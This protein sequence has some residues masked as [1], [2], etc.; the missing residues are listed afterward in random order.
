MVSLHRIIEDWMETNQ[1]ANRFHG[2]MYD[3]GMIWKPYHRH[4][5][6]VTEN[7]VEAHDK[8]MMFYLTG[9]DEELK[10]VLNAADPLFLEKL[11]KLLVDYA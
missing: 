3:E 11:G 8:G 7:T 10:I 6:G 1:D 9:K 4:W 5:F 2:W